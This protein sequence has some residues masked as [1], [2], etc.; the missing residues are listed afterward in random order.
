MTAEY[1]ILQ[2][3]LHQ[4]RELHQPQWENCINAC[5][6]GEQCRNRSRLCAE[7]GEYWPCETAKVVY[8][9]SELT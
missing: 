2:N 5:C 7:C 3:K 4:V 1:H 9:D 8:D 6:S